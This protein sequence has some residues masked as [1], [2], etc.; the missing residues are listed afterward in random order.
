M[1]SIFYLNKIKKCRGITFLSKTH[2]KDLKR[3]WNL[4]TLEKP[5]RK[6]LKIIESRKKTFKK[7]QIGSRKSI[8]EMESKYRGWMKCTVS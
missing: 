2:L 1:L 5:T 7:M 4:S 6:C 3:T 8:V